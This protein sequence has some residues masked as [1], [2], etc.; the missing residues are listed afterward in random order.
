MMDSEI[1]NPK[2]KI[3]YVD[4]EPGNLIGFKSHFRKE[5]DVHTCDSALK[6]LDEVMLHDF[7]MVI[8]N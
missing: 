6:A 8:T 2:I 4:D 7:A 5:F 1:N 3:L